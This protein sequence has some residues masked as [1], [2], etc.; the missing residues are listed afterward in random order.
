MG[1]SLCR[2]LKGTNESQLEQEAP[3]GRLQQDSDESQLETEAQ[4]EHE[5]QLE[6]E[7]SLARLPQGTD[8]TEL[9]QEAQEWVE[10][11]QASACA[12]YRPVLEER[13]EYIRQHLVQSFRHYPLDQT[14]ASIRLVHLLPDLSSEGLIQCTISHA[15]MS[16][17]YV[18]LS[19]VWEIPIRKTSEPP[20]NQNTRVV[21]MNGQPF[22]VM[23]NLFEFL[24]MARHN[25]TRTNWDLKQFNLSIPFWIDAICIDQLNNSERSH[26]VQQMGNIYSHAQSVQVWLGVAPS[27][28]S[29]G[30]IL[31][32]LPEVGQYRSGLE[33]LIYHWTRAIPKREGGPFPDRYWD[34]GMDLFDFVFQNPYWQRAWV[35]QEFFLATRIMIWIYT[36]PVDMMYLQRMR[37]CLYGPDIARECEQYQQYQRGILK[38]SRIKDSR[39]LNLLDALCRFQD[40][41]CKDPRDRVFSLLSL[42]PESLSS[43]AVDY[44]VPLSHLAYTVLSVQKSRVCICTAALVSGA[45]SEKTIGKPLTPQRMLDGPW[46]EF[47]IRP[48]FSKGHPLKSANYIFQSECKRAGL[49]LDI[50]GW[51]PAE[52]WTYCVRRAGAKAGARN[53]ATLRVPLCRLP[54]MVS[55]TGPVCQREVSSGSVRLGYGNSKKGSK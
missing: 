16:K 49:K 45:L 37:D 41:L 28:D 4:L 12:E 46:I 34:N 36:Y 29:D 23:R 32:T 10:A 6:Q 20:T 31:Q 33:K 44:D 47:D 1:A 25:A 21:L 7:A 52:R 17:T 2:L 53:G 18:C 39:N 27:F 55:L 38:D 30:G 24:Q 50:S 9:E 48:S 11:Y 3:L 43:I 14:Q 5:A 8:E 13:L 15:S 35:V 42:C 40:K 22:R 54:P 51:T 19:Y 26:Q